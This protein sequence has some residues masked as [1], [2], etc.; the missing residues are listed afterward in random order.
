[1]ED[2]G[3]PDT[4]GLSLPLSEVSPALGGVNGRG[5][6][7]RCGVT[8]IFASRVAWDSMRCTL[9]SDL[10]CVCVESI[11]F[12]LPSRIPLVFLGVF[13]ES[14]RCM[15]SSRTGPRAVQQTSGT[16]TA[17]LA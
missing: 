16:I 7:E 15:F 10:G 1:M 12:R 9:I 3:C 8:D 11:W 13:V 17:K 5:G 4:D 2:S 14:V 6:G